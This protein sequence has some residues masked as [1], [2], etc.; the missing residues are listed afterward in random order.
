MWLF[1]LHSTVKI[2][3]FFRFFPWLN[4]RLRHFADYFLGT[5]RKKTSTVFYG[6]AK[7][8]QP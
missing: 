4:L 8:K 1:Y 3:P 6:T 7:N 5:S 2:Q